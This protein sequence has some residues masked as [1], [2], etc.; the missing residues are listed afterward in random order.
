MTPDTKAGNY[1]GK[2]TTADWEEAIKSAWPPRH[3]PY[4]LAQ[5]LSGEC[6]VEETIDDLNSLA[7]G[8]KK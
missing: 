8:E 4:Y 7:E 1:G 6:T 2:P 5:I 3:V